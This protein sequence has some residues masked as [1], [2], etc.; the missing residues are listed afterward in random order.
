MQS[1]LATDI[2]TGMA[3]AGRL[4]HGGESQGPF[5]GPSSKAV[6]RKATGQFVSEVDKNY[7]KLGLRR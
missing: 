1:A 7:H 6:G 3:S 5:G 2:T 4:G